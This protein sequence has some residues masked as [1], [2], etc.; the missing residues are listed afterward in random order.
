MILTD[1]SKL[2]LGILA[3]TVLLVIGAIALFSRP[4]APAPAIPV[5]KLVLPTSS[6][7]GP[8][9]ASVILVEFSDFQCPAC[10]AAKPYIDTVLA[11]YATSV[12]FVYRHFPLDQH[13][14]GK[15]A[16]QAAEAA[17]LQGK[18]WDMYDGLFA[19][20]AS[21]SDETVRT[22]AKTLQLEINTFERDWKSASVAAIVEKDRAD[23][24]TF[25]VNATPTFFLNGRKMELASFGDLVSEVEKALNTR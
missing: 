14:Y 15:K 10:L 1:E 18:F 6:R 16:A 8:D 5:E 21:L 7:K 11:K 17:G 24:I 13:P 22:L 23:G 25:G 12:Q 3:G 4:A 9:Q 19:K 2:L 20:Q